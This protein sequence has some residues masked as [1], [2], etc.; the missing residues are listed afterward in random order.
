MRPRW[1]AHR[2]AP[3]FKQYVIGGLDTIMEHRSRDLF[4]PVIGDLERP[5][6]TAP[7]LC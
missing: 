4:E 2:N 5:T 7:Q 6:A 1:Q 3:Y